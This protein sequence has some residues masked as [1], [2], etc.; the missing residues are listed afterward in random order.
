MTLRAPDGRDD[1]LFDLTRW[2]RAGLSRF[3][4]VDGDAAVWL[5]ELRIALLGLYSR[6]I[7][8][9]DR[10][11]EKWRDLFLKSP[12]DR[13]LD[14][15]PGEFQEAVAWKDLMAAFPVEVETG[16]SR[17]LRLLQQYDRRSPDYAW[18]IMRAFARAAHSVLGHLDA[19]ANEG[20]LR[21][22]TQWENL[23]KL[24]AMVNY[25]PTPPASATATIALELEPDMGVIEIARGLAMKYAPPEG[26]APL[27]FETLKPV[28]AHPDLGGART[29]G[30]DKNL[31]P[32]PL[33]SPTT[34]IVPEDIELVDGSPAV[35]T[36]TSATT[37]GVTAYAGSLSQ[38]NHDK[39]AGLATLSFDPPP[40]ASPQTH[41][42]QLLI[43]PA[44]VQ[45][46][47]P[48]TDPTRNRLVIKVDKASGYSVND[49]VHVTPVGT[50]FLAVVVEVAGGYLT[51][52]S[53]EFPSGDVT[54]QAYTPFA[55]GAEGTIETPL[56]IDL[57]YY[58]RISGSGDPAISKER[59]GTRKEDADGTEVE[60]ASKHALPANAGGPG[61]SLIAGTRADAGVVIEDLAEEAPFGS[62][63][64]RFNGKPPKS[65]SQG[66]WYAARRL[67]GG[68]LKPIRVT[69]VRVEA[70]AYSIRFDRD[71]PVEPEATEFLGPMTQALHPFD[72]DRDQRDAVREGIATLEGLSPEA[73]NLVKA[74]RDIIV[75]HEKDDVRNA[76]LARLSAV[77]PQGGLLK[78]TLEPGPDFTGWQAGWTRFHLNTVDVSHGE[79]KDPKTLGSGDAA[80]RRQ[81]FQLKVTGVSFV[82]SNAAIAGVAPDMDVTVDG[83][84]WEYRDIAD[85]TAEDADAWS[86]AL[87]EDD[88][89]QI[90]FRRR[91]P[92]GTNNVAVSRHRVGV[93]AKGTGIPPW[94]FS[95]PMKKNRFVSGIVQPF[96]SA[97][98]ADREPVADIRVNAPS[99]LAANGRAVSLLDF[100]R[101][102]KR[103]SSV[104]Q[105]K[106]REVIGPGAV[107]HV[108]VVIVPANGGAVTPTLEQDLIDFVESRA[109]PNVQVTIS[110]YRT[111]AIEMH[112]KIQVDTGRY[113][114]AD[115]KDSAEAALVAEFALNNRGLGQPLYV[116]EILAAIERVEGASSGTI[117]HFGRLRTLPKPLREAELSGSLVAIFPTEEQV[118]V[119]PGLAN[120]TVDVE[121][122]A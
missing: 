43:E 28:F 74:H 71:T 102:C 109:L 94:S 112:V 23:R 83:V 1:F 52:D 90:H 111:L 38:V 17:N 7:D 27:I 34:W 122:L 36:I 79:T 31:S 30:W 42:T 45:F 120:V 16:G 11:P 61:Y 78:L 25:Q 44:D 69:R 103:H 50:S 35:I 40:T 104:W 6:G 60:V 92:T 49:I 62:R 66:A 13:Q 82:P 20:Y 119:L 41:Q 59:T 33:G 114:K 10:V 77:E 55:A 15:S 100:E 21:T 22:A 54:V 68:P 48:K 29:E 70:D 101:L 95:K 108:D 84:K 76:V 96:A 51:L 116:A 24:A 87:N 72:H 18:E 75:V 113:E 73:Q 99:S 89:L 14:A 39:D 80:R 19:Y 63:T 9:D 85:P 37:L 12:E 93:G 91:L 67:A 47:L 8:A 56:D 97:G 110:P 121:G 5:E 57:L 106:A 53:L 4:Y 88:T 32:L 46:G 86:V 115:V 26:G 65:L 64:V 105:A 3:Q 2:N 118:V 117:T 107:N 81:D 58:R 98:G